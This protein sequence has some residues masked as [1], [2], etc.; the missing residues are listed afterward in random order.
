MCNL[1]L[2]SHALGSLHTRISRRDEVGGHCSSSEAQC[3]AAPRARIS[4]AVTGTAIRFSGGGIGH[5]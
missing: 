5:E 4:P 1:L 2:F 3:G